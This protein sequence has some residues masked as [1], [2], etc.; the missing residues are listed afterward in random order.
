MVFHSL[1]SKLCVLARH[2]NERSTGRIDFKEGCKLCIKHSSSPCDERMTKMTF[3][4]AS[5]MKV[6]FP[7][8]DKKS[9]RNEEKKH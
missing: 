6:I 8:S 9:F 1:K 3:D 7:D 5:N 2:C 4:A